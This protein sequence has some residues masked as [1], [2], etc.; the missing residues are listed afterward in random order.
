MGCGPSVGGAHELGV[1]PGVWVHMAGA[2][3][4]VVTEVQRAT[5]QCSKKHF[6]VFLL[7]CSK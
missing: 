6:L 3:V 4:A 7:L 5:T 1:V 2:D